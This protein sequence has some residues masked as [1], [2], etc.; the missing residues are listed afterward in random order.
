MC[1]CLR[2]ITS[3]ISSLQVIVAF[4]YIANVLVVVSKAKAYI[5]ARSGCKTSASVNDALSDIIRSQC[6]RA[7]SRAMAEGRGTIMGRDFDE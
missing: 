4:I 3:I 1:I 2:T 7:M 6:D 5:L